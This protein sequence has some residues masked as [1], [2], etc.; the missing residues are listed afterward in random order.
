M[1]FLYEYHLYFEWAALFSYLTSTID[2]CSIEKNQRYKSVFRACTSKHLYKGIIVLA[3]VVAATLI[4]TFGMTLNSK[5]CLRP[6]NGT[7]NFI[8]FIITA[9]IILAK[10]TT[11]A[12]RAAR[13]TNR[14]Y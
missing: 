9:M 13:G 12:A 10:I 7:Q 8:L 1:F 4:T 11:I 2:T 5:L 3:F 14:L 6:D